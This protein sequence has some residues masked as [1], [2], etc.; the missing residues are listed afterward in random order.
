[1]NV[2]ANYCRAKIDNLLNSG[3]SEIVRGVWVNIYITIRA[4]WEFPI[5]C[6]EPTVTCKLHCGSSDDGL[7]LI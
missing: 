5:L 4:G 3:C 6:F 7:Q 1:M 2:L